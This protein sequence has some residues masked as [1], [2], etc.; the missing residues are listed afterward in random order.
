MMMKGLLVGVGAALVATVVGAAD[1]SACRRAYGSYC[2]PPVAFPYGPSPSYGYVPPAPVY[3]YGFGPPPG[4]YEVPPPPYAAP[5]YGYGADDNGG[6][7]G[8]RGP[9][10]CGRGYGYAPPVGAYY[11]GGF[12]GYQPVG[13][14]VP[15]R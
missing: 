11:G 5:V 4:A 15:V 7:Y 6:Y 12:G 10:R 3:G 14:W 9:R 1:A 13:V 2:A 8:Y